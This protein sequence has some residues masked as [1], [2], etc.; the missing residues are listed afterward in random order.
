[1]GI[2][3]DLLFG[4]DDTSFESSDSYGGLRMQE[5]AS[6]VGRAGV[7]VHP[8]MLVYGLAGWSVQSYEA[9]T[10]TEWYSN[11]HSGF[12]NGPTVGF[13]AEVVLPNDPLFSLKGEYRFTHLSAPTDGGTPSYGLTSSFNSVND[14]QF[15]VILS[16]KLGH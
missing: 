1:L 12:V 16:I 6:V 11:E 13:G 15:R 5:R 2:Y 7:L 8:N 9:S 4:G 10:S 14:R 3:G